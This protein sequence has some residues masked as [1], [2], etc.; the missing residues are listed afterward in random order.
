MPA[1]IQP[2]R[3]QERLSSPE[4]RAAMLE[5]AVL[6]NP[7]LQVSRIEFERPGPSYTVDTLTLL[8]ERYPRGSEFFFILGSDAIAE[9]PRW[10]DPERLMTL[11]RFVVFQR[12]GCDFDPRNLFLQFPRLRERT[13]FLEGPRLEISATELRRRVRQGLPIRYQTPDAVEEYIRSHRLYL[14]D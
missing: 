8:H 2:L 7:G 1:R 11:C 10:K 4:D 9:L 3:Q 5:R 14:E 6:G 12:P 13:I